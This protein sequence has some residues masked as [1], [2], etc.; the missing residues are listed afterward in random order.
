M[1]GWIDIFFF[2]EDGGLRVKILICLSIVI[3]LFVIIVF[4]LL[5]MWS[6]MIL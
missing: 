5:I 3:V 4:D 6:F 2:I 1:I